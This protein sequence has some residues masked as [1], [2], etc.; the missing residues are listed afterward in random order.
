VAPTVPYE[1]GLHEVA[2]GVFAWLQPDGGWGW[3]N[4]GLVRG[5][6]GSLLVDTL[7]DLDLTRAMLDAMAPIT[8]TDPIATLVNTHAN[9]DHCYGNQ[10]VGGAEVI[11]SAASAAEMEQLPPSALSLMTTMDLGDAANR[12]VRDAFGPFRFDD[13]DPP[14]P[15]RT[16]SDRLELEVAGE[17]VELVE[18]G[19]AHT[20][21]DVLVHLPDRRTVFTG[22]ILFVGGT[23]IVWDGPIHNWLDAC[24]RIL[25]FDA[26]VIV[27]GHG[28]LTG[29][30]GVR[31]TADYLR[32]VRDEATQRHGAGLTVTEA[33]WDIDLGPYAD[34][35]ESERIA[36]NVDAVY[37]EL[38]PTH[39]SPGVLALF[40]TMGEL[41]DARS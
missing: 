26:D 12:Y 38:D 36:I 31:Q 28:P 40:T 1:R 2:D 15:D 7:F 24:D 4:A 22:D 14:H 9:G 21:G 35:G 33:A 18:V 32:F 10:L 27:P 29:A 19:P 11:A 20:A 16:F 3:S 25:A 39:E 30:E 13:I 41:K 23:P 37:R 17:A 6:G 34:W 5:D 8:A